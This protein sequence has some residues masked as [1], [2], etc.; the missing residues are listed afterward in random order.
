[1]DWYEFRHSDFSPSPEQASIRDAFRDFYRRE[2]PTT[3]VRA[4][5]PLGFDHD[6]WKQLVDLGA[7]SMAVPSAFG[8]DDAELV[9][10]VMI[11]E[12]HGSALAP[13]PLIEHVVASRLLAATGVADADLIQAAVSG[14]QI[15]TLALRP[16]SAESQLVPAGAVVRKV[17][18]LDA[19]QLVVFDAVASPPLVANQGSAP[20]A[21]WNLASTPRQTLIEGDAAER[22]YHEAVGEWKLLTAAALVGLTE[23]AL[24]IAVEFAKVRQTMGVPIG[25]LQGVAFPLVDVKIGVTGARNLVLKAAWYLG[26]EPLERPDLTP[27]AFAYAARVATQG[28]STAQ[29]MQGGLGF[30]KEADVS[31]YLLRAKAWSVLAGDPAED[32]QA[33]GR[34]L[35]G[36]HAG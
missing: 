17:L 18:A 23:S 30:T 5:E 12:E 7:T 11:A 14:S 22:L 15:M 3:R 21:F 31:L 16:V 1:M 27:A 34:L 32:V 25:S 19:G 8:G 26:N 4:A 10:L 33:V 13:A 35:V 20:L 2:V 28:T 29:H 24:A 6:L 9:D 36:D